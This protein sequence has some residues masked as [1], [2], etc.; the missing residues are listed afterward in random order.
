MKI[1][2]GVL[3]GGCFSTLEYSS[4]GIWNPKATGWILCG[5][6]LFLELY[7]WLISR[8]F[9]VIMHTLSRVWSL[10]LLI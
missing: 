5:L 6:S 10:T 8:L 9:S 3:K 2:I 4:M 1:G 7:S